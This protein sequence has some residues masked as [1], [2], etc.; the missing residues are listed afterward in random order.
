MSTL[1][2][3]VSAAL[4]AAVAAAAL[5]PLFARLAVLGG[6]VSAPR[7]DRWGARPT[8]LFGGLAIAL[9]VIAAF[10]LFAPLDG[11][12]MAV[13]A[14]TLG[15]LGLG[16]FD[17]IRALR[18]TSKLVGQVTIASGLALAGV[19]VQFIEFAPLAFLLTL[20]WVVGMMNAVNLIDNMDGLAAGVV[21]I[22]AG[23]LVLLG[24]PTWTQVLA[25]ATAGACIGFL[26]HNFA[27]AKVY[28]GD[29]GSMALG[30]ILAALALLLTRT[31][32]SGVGFAV[33]GPLLVLGLPIFDTALVSIVRT[34]EGRPLGAGGRD[35]S[36][37][38]LA[39]R[40]LSEREAVLTLYVVAAALASIGFFAS[41]AGIAVLPLVGLAL[42]G[43]VLFGVF[44][45]DRPERTLTEPGTAARSRVLA[46]GRI[47][48]R[49]GAEIALDVALAAIA[50]FSAFRLRFEATPIAD[51]LPHFQQAAAVVIPIQLAAF[52][53]LGVYRILWSY[54]GIPDLLVIMRA[55]LIGTLSAGILMLYGF[56]WV[57]QSRGVLVLD[58]VFLAGGVIAA[59]ASLLWLRHW[60][61]MRP[62]V[63]DRRVLIVGATTSGE[64]ALRLL[65]RSRE[66]P[67]H[68]TG[69]LDDDP[70]KQRRRVAGVPV[71][72]RIA[73]LDRVARSERADLIIVAV[74]DHDERERVRARCEQ[75]GLEAREFA[76]SF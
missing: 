67:Y 25:A 23:V 15:A 50:L 74:E 12:A 54:L 17:D 34:I 3:V 16:L 59:R 8:P 46:S 18:P 64:T 1:V 60:I 71:L 62:K 68:P 72:G 30:F 45:A 47:L 5:T 19:H 26:I 51:W 22:A 48:V 24:G 2:I 6:V 37:H 29:A 70:A 9:T 31:A 58:L 52:V 27:P 39:A 43:L 63:G 32:A 56:G 75:L 11:A 40:G 14:G 49:Y 10:L 65:L 20:L 33:L 4:F 38:R 7:L 61:E 66:V 69:F 13:L 57:H 28:M 53:V 55:A 73:D 42:L 35:H 76:R 44:L 21:A 36:S 41:T